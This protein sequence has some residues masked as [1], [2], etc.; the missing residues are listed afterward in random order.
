MGDHPIQPSSIN[1]E[2]LSAIDLEEMNKY[3]KLQTRIDRKYIVTPEICNAL[4]AGA[5]IN[6]RALEINCYRSTRYQSTY[7][8]T[9]TLDLHKAAAYRRRP[10]FKARTRYYQ[11]TNTA[12]LEVKTKDGRG[13]TVKIRTE[14]DSETL[15]SLNKQGRQFINSIVEEKEIVKD[16]RRTL[17]TNYQRTTIVDLATQ[18]RMTCDEFL[19]CSDWEN[20]TI[21][22]PMIIL[23]TKSSQ[24]P[25]PFDRWL[26]SHNLRPSRISKY[27]TTLAVL[28][29][30]L[31]SNKW[32]TTITTYF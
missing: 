15:N 7:F 11:Q 4:L 14:Y 27:C 9:P 28:H 8:D 5:E 30:E 3:A 20:N 26:W 21:S 25:S 23:E 2:L 13:K 29:P 6:G 10:R 19:T 18:T 24:N 32:N 1:T 17:T 16:L 31:P 22:L 12:M